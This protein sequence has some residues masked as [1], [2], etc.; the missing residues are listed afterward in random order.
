MAAPR[1]TNAALAVTIGL[2][3]GLIIIIGVIV[4]AM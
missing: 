4:V 3:I 1:Q 2:L